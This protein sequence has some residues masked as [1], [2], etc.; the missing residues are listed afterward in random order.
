M[1]ESKE[2]A[3]RGPHEIE[4]RVFSL[5]EG[6]TGLRAQELRANPNLQLNSTIDGD[7][8]MELMDSFAREF[9]VDMKTYSHDHYFGR[10]GIRDPISTIVGWFKKSSDSGYRPLTARDLVS[11]AMAKQWPSDM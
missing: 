11:A 1:S 7:D 4:E 2:T 3:T 10:E 8:A 5:I 9:S 6:V